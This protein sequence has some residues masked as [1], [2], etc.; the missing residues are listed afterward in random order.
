MEEENLNITEK[1]K[2]LLDNFKSINQNYSINI[3]TEEDFKKIPLMTRKEAIEFNIEKC[4]INPSYIETTSGTTGPGFLLF[5]NDKS[6]EHYIK[7]INQIYQAY[8]PNNEKG[9]MIN[10][11]DTMFYNLMIIKNKNPFIHGGLL[12]PKNKD[13][14][15]YKIKTMK[16]KVLICYTMGLIDLLKTINDKNTIELIFCGG[17]LVTESF[18][19]KAK[20][21]TNAK[22]IPV[23]ACTEVGP[24]GHYNSTYEGY[25]KLIEEGLYI[26][27][28]NENKEIKRIGKGNIIITDLNNFSMPIIRYALG[29]IVEIIEKDNQ[30]YIKIFGRSDK[31]TKIG[32]DIIPVGHLM[33][34]IT[35]ILGHGNFYIKVELDDTSTDNIFV[36]VP[37][38]DLIKKET[39]IK[40]FNDMFDVKAYVEELKNGIPTTNTGKPRFF[41]DNRKLE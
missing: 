7:R 28:L 18:L 15:A 40:L 29:D 6:A 32:G 12:T 41:I 24:I 9:K 17:S 2:R 27:I 38:E 23:Y 10:L 36:F 25:Y 22:I 30:K 13:L 1:M 5:F 8:N 39:I 11:I 37:K 19:N 3:T 20:E 35:P 34:L 33:N 21:L 14:I 16:P 26:E 4:P 31:Y